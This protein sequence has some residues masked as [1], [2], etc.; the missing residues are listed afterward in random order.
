MG[1][2]F[3]ACLQQKKS[4][5]E[6]PPIVGEESTSL[7]TNQ[8][9]KSARV[10][11]SRRKKS[12]SATIPRVWSRGGRNSRV[13]PCDNGSAGNAGGINTSQEGSNNSSRTSQPGSDS[14]GLSESYVETLSSS[15]IFQEYLSGSC[16]QPFEENPKTRTPTPFIQ[17]G[18]T[19]GR[20]IIVQPCR[21]MSW[22]SHEE[23]S[24][25]N[26]PCVSAAKM[27]INEESETVQ[28]C[29][30]CSS[31]SSIGTWTDDPVDI[32]LDAQSEEESCQVFPYPGI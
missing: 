8:S 1:N 3:A 31:S 27:P 22:T 20:L 32:E 29:E 5:P 21:S 28:S 14:S 30:T 17:P 9:L 26:V 18:V 24:P 16:S 12:A 15:S 11:R 13:S 25:E 4:V 7:T 19:K 23:T 6:I 2:C 10:A